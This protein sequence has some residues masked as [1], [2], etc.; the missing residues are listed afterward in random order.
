MFDGE[1]QVRKNERNPVIY[2]T[3]LEYENRFLE[4]LGLFT[5]AVSRGKKVFVIDEEYPAMEEESIGIKILE[6]VP[7]L[8]YSHT[9]YYDLENRGLI[10]SDFITTVEFVAFHGTPM[11]TLTMLANAFRSMDELKYELLQKWN[12]SFMDTTNVSENNTIYD[13]I[14]T[15]KKAS[16]ICRFNTRVMVRDLLPTEYIETIKFKIKQNE[17]VFDDPNRIDLNG[18]VT[19]IHV[20]DQE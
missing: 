6:V 7:S 19:Y 8:A 17:S 12:I 13:S 3:P 1:S 18:E 14:Q 20:P 16:V 9:G 2:D 4:Q 5:H 15:I 11:I 10:V